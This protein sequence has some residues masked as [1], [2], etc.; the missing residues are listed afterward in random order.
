[1]SII[2]KCGLIEKYY[3]R[4]SKSNC[5]LQQVVNINQQFHLL[6]QRKDLSLHY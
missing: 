3:S 5:V 4:N 1:M 6:K 2:L